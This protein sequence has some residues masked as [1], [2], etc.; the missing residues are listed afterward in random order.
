M[1]W[2]ATLSG[3]L[4][5]TS[6]AH[7]GLRTRL[8]GT[9]EA[10]DYDDNPAEVNFLRIHADEMDDDDEDEDEDE[11][12][13]DGSEDGDDGSSNGNG[14]DTPHKAT[15]APQRRR[16][17]MRSRGRG[18]AGIADRIH[19][20]I[21]S[22]SSPG[23]PGQPGALVYLSIDIDVLDPAYAPGTG[24]PEP[25]GWTTRELV[26][27]L[28]GALRGKTVVGVDLVEVSPPYDGRGEQTALAA[29]QIV[30]E[31]LSILVK[32]GEIRRAS[33][34]RGGMKR[35]QRKKAKTKAKAKAKT[36][37]ENENRKVAGGAKAASGG[38]RV[39]V[40][41]GGGGGGVRGGEGGERWWQMAR[42]EL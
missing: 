1:F 29:A 32:E 11:S 3:L 25:A 8:V 34:G 19:A 20:H 17:S 21:P 38:E 39:K 26:R 24:T 6:S 7:A 33:D 22:S 18:A 15:A 41:E 28:R 14:G 2:T 23:S 12:E 9:S 36:E 30:F 35:T 27:V 5:N 10:E 31:V 4:S 13:E 37:N 16:K 42:N 40:Q